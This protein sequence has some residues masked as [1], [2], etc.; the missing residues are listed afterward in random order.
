MY[1]KTSVKWLLEGWKKYNCYSS[2]WSCRQFLL[3]LWI[4][5][6]I[7][8]LGVGK[9]FNSIFER[10]LNKNTIK[11]NIVKW[12]QFQIT[13]IFKCNLFLR[14]HSWIFS[15]ITHS[16]SHAPSEIILIC[17]Y[18]L[19]KSSVTNVF[20]VTFDQCNAYLLKI[21]YIFQKKKKK[22]YMFHAYGNIVLI[23]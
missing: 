20:T 23:Q 12:L 15:I 10:R 8:K 9:I 11:S 22:Q 21:I 14:W 1:C 3:I 17:W 18:S 6:T 19:H 4:L 13:S 16:V 2:N 5:T 7:Q